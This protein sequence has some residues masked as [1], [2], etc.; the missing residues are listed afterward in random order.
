MK[1]LVPPGTTPE[2]SVIAAQSAANM[3]RP[4]YVTEALLSLTAV[5]RGFVRDGCLHG[6]VTMTTVRALRRKGLFYLKITSPNGKAGF[7]ELTPLG[8]TV[9]SILLARNASITDASPTP[10][11]T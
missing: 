7:M 4:P 2:A 10:G 6:D 5:Q 3:S 9:R 11:M 8:E 1:D